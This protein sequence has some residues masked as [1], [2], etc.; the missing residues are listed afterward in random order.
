MKKFL[1]LCAAAIMIASSAIAQSTFTS[2][3]PVK[4][5]KG[6]NIV[7]VV[8]ADG[9]PMQGVIVSDGYE[10]TTTDKKGCYYLNSAK[11]NGNVFITIPSGYEVNVEGAIPHYW[12]LLNAPATETERHDFA[13]K[14]VNNDRHAIMAVTDIHLA[15]QSEDLKQFKTKFMPRLNEE[16][17]KFRSQGI[18]VYTICM[19]DSSFDTFWYDF[20]FDIGTFRQTLADVKY[21]TAVFHTMGNHDNDG[22]TPY[23]ENTDFNATEKYRKAFG[24]TYY[25]FNIGKIH[26]I[27]L[28]NVV[29]I[30]KPTADQKPG[31]NI[32]GSRNHVHYVTD[33]QLEWLKKDLAFVKD[34]NTPIVIGMHCPIIRYKNLNNGPIKI[35]TKEEETVKLLEILKDYSD[36][37]LFTGHNHRN[38]TCHGKDDPTQPLIGNI[39][40]HNISAVCGAWWSTAAHGGLTLSKE[41]LPAGFEVFSM[42]GRNMEWY[43]SS[44]DEGSDKQFRT[45]DMNTVRKYFNEDPEVRVFYDHYPPKARFDLRKTKDNRVDINV[46][47]WETTWKISVKEV[48]TGKMLDVKESPSENPLAILSYYIPK[49]VWARSFRSK[50]KSR[51]RNPHMFHTVASAPDTTLEITVTDGFGREYKETMIRPKEF[52]K[53]MR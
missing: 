32:A 21:P 33:E 11:K 52:S 19:G 42:D 15:N 16:V 34:K 31:K 8:E 26:Y 14:S 4:N 24:P 35:L 5:R 49:T 9:K 38:F 48:E 47:A 22:A 45:F 20:L 51:S 44:L 28:D 39:I 6:A 2:Q 27:M 40:D 41:A 1:S 36:V 7:G 50:Y 43:F 3:F 53:T 17:E 12:A 10:V 23:D 25:S 37:H 30:N 46:Y 29:Y 18:P 13:L